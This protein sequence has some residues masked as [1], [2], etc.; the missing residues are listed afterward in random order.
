MIGISPL[1]RGEKRVAL[2]WVGDGA[3]R[4]GEFHEGFNF[5]ALPLEDPS[6]IE[7]KIA[8]LVAGYERRTRAVVAARNEFLTKYRHN[9]GSPLLYVIV[10][11]GNIYEDV[12]QAQAAGEQGA[13]IVITLAAGQP[14]P[15]KIVEVEFTMPRN[16]PARPENSMSRKY[17][18]SDSTVIFQTL[19]LE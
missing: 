19:T 12:K 2:T 7:A 3:S 18:W 5:A 15:V 11:T 8:E 14:V 17:T 4:T 16:T 6:R 13:D 9:E 1:I 10:A